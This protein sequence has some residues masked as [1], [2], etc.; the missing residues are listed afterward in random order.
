MFIN[1]TIIVG[2]LTR[3]PEL[4]SLPSGMK[5]CSFGVATNRT[6]K[7]KDGVKQEE[8][9]YHNITAFGKTA[10]T[11]AQWMDKGSQIFVEGRL[12]TSSW[13]KDEIKHYKTEIIV[14]TFQFGSNKPKNETKP[15]TQV[16]TQN[17]ANKPAT[18]QKNSKD[19]GVD[20]IEYP[21]EEINPEDI[22]F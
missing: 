13:E 11:I 20:T 9:E 2:N 6:W 12:K 21:S 14:E 18:E 10:E 7:N 4:K 5:V 19:E 22:P 8:V 1:K 15:A 16:N 3:K 17:T